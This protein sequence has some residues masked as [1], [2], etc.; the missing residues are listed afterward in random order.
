MPHQLTCPQAWP[1][2]CST[3]AHHYRGLRP[4][5]HLQFLQVMATNILGCFR[6]KGSGPVGITTLGRHVKR[7]PLRRMKVLRGAREKGKAKR[8]DTA[9]CPL[10]DSSRFSSLI[11][12]GCSSPTSCTTHRSS[13]GRSSISLPSFPMCCGAPF[14]PWSTTAEPGLNGVTR[15][16]AEIIDE[17]ATSV[18]HSVFKIGASLSRSAA[19]KA[20]LNSYRSWLPIYFA[21][22]AT[23]AVVLWE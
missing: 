12:N 18:A 13:S 14:K 23:K 8:E 10:G 9:L 17:D 3:L 16:P 5:K 2:R 19:C 20:P 6:N 7:G 22:L 4:A 11:L 1:T 15:S 21:V